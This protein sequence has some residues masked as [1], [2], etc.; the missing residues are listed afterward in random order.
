[1]RVKVKGYKRKGKSVKG[2]TRVVRKT[3]KERR[4]K[5]NGYYKGD[6]VKKGKGKKVSKR[7]IQLDRARKGRK[8]EVWER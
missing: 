6:K 2:Y 4:T 5:A 8:Y 7:S 1:M 3:K